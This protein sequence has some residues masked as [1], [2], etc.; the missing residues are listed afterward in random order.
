[1]SGARVAI[2]ACRRAGVTLLVNGWGIHAYPKA[3]LL[4]R[5]GLASMVLRYKPEICTL[6]DGLVE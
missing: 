4:A 1:M 2:D 6:L 5:P 3:L